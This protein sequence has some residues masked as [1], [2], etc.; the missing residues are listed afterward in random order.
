MR[1]ACV[2]IAHLRVKVALHG[3]PLLRGRPVVIIDRS[4]RTAVVVDYS[5]AAAGVAAGMTLEQ[6]MSQ[7]ADTVALDADERSCERAFNEVVTA[8]QGVSDLVEGAEPGRAWVR[9]DGLGAAYGGEE[10]LLER[11]LPGCA[12]G[13]LMPRIGVGNA[14]FPTLVA[15]RLAKD[16]GRVTVP[17]EVSSFLAPHS[18]DH[19]PLAAEVK[20]AMHRFGLH[21]MGAVAAMRKHQVVDQ[22]GPA[23]RRAWELSQGIDESPLVPVSTEETVVEHSVLPCG[24]ASL[25]HLLATV[26]TLIGRAWSRPR[27]QGRQAGQA[28]L[29]CLLSDAPAWQK[30]VHFKRGAAG[31]ERAMFVMKSQLEM[32]HPQ[33]PVEELTLT[34]AGLRGATGVQLELLP[35]VRRDRHQ[36]L[37]EVEK[38][39]QART[40]GRQ[41]LFRALNV[42]P[43]HPVPEMRALQ[44]P[45][46][47][48]ENGEI[49]PL[50]LPTPVAVREGADHRP[51]ALRLGKRWSRVTQIEERWCFDLW[52]LP[53]PLTRS[54]YRIC[55]EDGRTSTLFRDMRGKGWYR[56]GPEAGVLP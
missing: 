7:Q 39:L 26:E 27:M 43:W 38:D 8:L 51:L 9:L 42:A 31:R 46:D 56:Q 22:F 2:L 44:I 21:S 33:A 36:R 4:G 45:I 6:A 28:E 53:Q 48:A 55:S 52:W 35:D 19:L 32:D 49:R 1:I 11:I 47:A 29:E 13:Y 18:I 10:R 3:Q 15:A 54:Y 34:L 17:A 30:T 16:G 20:A 37:V 14:K 25:Q 23:G 50:A 5:A 41:V 40:R 12:P 24:A